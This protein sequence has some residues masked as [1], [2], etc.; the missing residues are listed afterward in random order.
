MNNYA[1]VV[2]IVEGKTEQVFIASVLTPY[3]AERNVYLSATQVSK[4]GQKGGDVR[5][6]RTLADIGLHL[7]QRPNTYI[8][9][10]V[11]YYGLKSW[12]GLEQLPALATPAQIADALNRAAYDSVVARFAPQQAER[13]FIPF[14]V[15]HEFEALLFSNSEILACE[16]GIRQADIDR[17]IAH[18]GGP[19]G[20]NN[21]PHTAP[22]KRLDGWSAHG[23]FA[24][25]TVGITLADRI[26]IPRI[27]EQ[28]PLFDRWLSQMEALVGA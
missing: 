24:K 1:E 22:S 26:G 17:V 18:S 9:T 2:A 16:L 6:D 28:C 10:M 4:P 19:E 23:K 27:R 21:S 20:I 14:M 13:R 7:K 12:P 8:T 3:L 15:M 25:T 11:D 5:F